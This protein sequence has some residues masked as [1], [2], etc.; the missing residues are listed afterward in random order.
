[1][2]VRRP[3]GPIARLAEGDAGEDAASLNVLTDQDIEVA[4]SAGSAG[5]AGGLL[6]LGS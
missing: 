5:L 2:F 4:R 3:G 6:G 1:M